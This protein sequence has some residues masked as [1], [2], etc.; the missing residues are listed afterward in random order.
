MAA[1]LEALRP[2]IEIIVK[3]TLELF[4]EKA[5]APDTVVEADRCRG[6]RDRL[7][8]RVRRHKDRARPPGE[9]VQLAE[10]VKARIY[11]EVG[12][13]RVRSENPVV[14]PEGWLCLPD[15][16]GYRKKDLAVSTRSSQVGLL[17]LMKPYSP[18]GGLLRYVLGERDI[19]L[20]HVL[21]TKPPLNLVRLLLLLPYVDGLLDPMHSMGGLALEYEQRSQVFRWIINRLGTA[22]EL[23]RRDIP[24]VIEDY[25]GSG[26]G[27]AGLR[28]EAAWNQRPGHCEHRLNT[29]LSVGSFVLAGY[30]CRR[31]W[32]WGTAGARSPYGQDSPEKHDGKTSAGNAVREAVFHVN[33]SL[34]AGA[35]VSWRQVRPVN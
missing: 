11:V 21:Q 6:R 23:K 13:Q 2:V 32:A 18:G 14:L 5:N 8:E 3:A 22:Y 31:R 9:P 27:Q 20:R 28:I 4:L 29:P 24:Q 10:P 1:L 16:A 19:E 26:P 15:P 34:P 17:M 7:A 12:G 33:V 35:T 25:I 30:V